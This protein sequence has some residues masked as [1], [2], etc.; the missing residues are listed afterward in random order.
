M[1]SILYTDVRKGQV[2][3]EEGTLFAVLDRDLRTPG[4]LPSKLTLTLKN[5]KTGY[6]KQ[7]RVH[8]EDKV[9]VAYL[10][11]RKMQYLYREGSEYVF[12]DSETFDQISLS[13][14][15]LEG[16]HGYIKENDEVQM[17]F[18]ENRPLSVQ[19]PATVIL[20]ITECDPALAGATA[21][22]QTKRATLETGLKV[23]VPS[24]IEQGEMV[25]VNTSTGE[26]AGRHKE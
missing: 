7:V 22:A 25:I 21:K 4:N 11:I 5:L 17:T 8:P 14:D 20:Q 13:V 10:E 24:F 6:V 18:H 2:I 1:A 15:A 3:N 9:E 19:P 16:V 12:M 23:M 26:Y